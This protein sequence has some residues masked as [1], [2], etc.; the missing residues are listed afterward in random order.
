MGIKDE[1]RVYFRNREDDYNKGN[2]YVYKTPYDSDYDD[3]SSV[4][5]GEIDSGGWV[6]WRP[7]E[8]EDCNE[9]EVCEEYL[10][11]KFGKDLKE[12]LNS[13]R[14]IDIE[15]KYKV[16][17]IVMTPLLKGMNGIKDS[18]GEIKKV[19][20]EYMIPVG[21][22]DN[23]VGTLYVGNTTGIV[24]LEDYENGKL[25]KMSEGIEELLNGINNG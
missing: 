6:E 10:G 21:Y 3:I 2:A 15:G 22:E 17:N 12:Y 9:I 18:K 4:T 8:V 7:K 19:K 16:Y 1:L 14:F 25:S 24:Y 13:Y 23:T 5:F 11:L 20:G